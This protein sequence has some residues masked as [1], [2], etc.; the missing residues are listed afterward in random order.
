MPVDGTQKT[1]SAGAEVSFR[2]RV[3]SSYYLLRS[4]LGGQF[5]TTGILPLNGDDTPDLPSRRGSEVGHS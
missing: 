5:Q 2:T 4:F 3:H 1:V